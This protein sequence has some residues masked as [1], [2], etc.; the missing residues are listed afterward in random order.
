MTIDQHPAPTVAHVASPTR[1]SATPLYGYRFQSRQT[2]PPAEPSLI[3]DTDGLIRELFACGFNVASVQSRYDVGPDFS[4]HLTALIA[5]LD[6]AIR[7]LRNALG[8]FEG[9]VRR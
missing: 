4:E 6:G 8:E 3:G 7:G 5:V 9:C 1:G 2:Q